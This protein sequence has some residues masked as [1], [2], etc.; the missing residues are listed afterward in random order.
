MSKEKYYMSLKVVLVL[1]LFVLL[2]ACG[3]ADEPER[4]SDGPNDQKVLAEFK[5]AK[6]G[7]PILLPITFKG[8]EYLFLLDTGCS[9]TVFD[10][11]FKHK[12]GDVKKIERAL[13]AGSRIVAELFDAPEAFLGPLNVKDCDE[14]ACFDLKMVSSV[15]GR[16]ISGAIGMNFLKK[17]MVQIDFDKGTLSFLQQVEEQHPDWGIELAMRYDSLGWLYITGDILNSINVDFMIDTGANST[18][19]LDSDVFKQILSEKE[20]KT[21]EILFATA[22]GVIQKKEIRIDS[23]SVGAL[24]Y[25]QL[26]FGEANWSYLGLLFLSR[27]IVTFDFPN[28]RMYLKKSKEF[29]KIDETDMSGLH[30]LR[31]SNQTVVYSVDEGSPAQKAGIKA[32]DVILKVGDKD[33]NTY[34]ILKLRRFLMSEDKRNIMMTIKHGDDVKDV[35][36]LLKKKI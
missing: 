18:G 15:L 13:T 17:Y 24:E 25:D 36:F 10:T 8:K 32:N 34:D 5:I 30:L 11:S 4:A 29:K 27:H 1:S 6:G 2:P 12:L 14:V 7:D 22:S 20:L 16:K 26:I 19:G 3:C 28:S 31:M 23:L 9:H 21:S 35:S 33:A